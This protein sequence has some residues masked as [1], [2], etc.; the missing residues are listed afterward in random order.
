MTIRQMVEDSQRQF[1]SPHACM[2]SR[3]RQYPVTPDDLRTEFARDRDRILHC[4]AFRRLKHKTQMLL[5]PQGDHYRTRLTHT[6]E[7]A[8]IARSCARALRLNEDL[9]EAIALGHDLGHTPF[10]HSGERILRRLLG[11]FEHA[12]QSLRVVDFLENDGQGLNLT[13]EVRDGILNH[14]GDGQPGTHEGE[15]CGLC[16]RIAYVNH[17]IDDAMRCGLLSDADLPRRC[18]QVLGPT[19]GQRIDTM[20]RDVVA[21][22]QDGPIAMS[23]EVGRAL[24]ELRSFLFANVYNRTID[25]RQEE[26]AA[27]VM[28]HLF[29]YYK[30]NPILCPTAPPPPSPAT[31]L[32]PFLPPPG[33]DQPIVDFIAGMAD[34]FALEA[35]REIF[36]PRPLV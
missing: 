1:C 28:E 23:D 20:I 19:H 6:M 27:F 36:M 34:G 2:D 4:K 5:S 17:D 30:D 16:D 3:G 24:D 7:V 31:P 14:S 21:N 10:G 11:H 25:A 8:Q 32:P 26:R 12:E 22:S 15:L 13:Q 35:F 29:A 33:P 9:T 18:I